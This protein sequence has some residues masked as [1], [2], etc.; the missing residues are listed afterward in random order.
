MFVLTADQ[1]G[2]RR[3]GDRVPAALALLAKIETALPFERTVGDEIQG[4]PADA[5]SALEAALTLIREGGWSIGI[6]IGPGRLTESAPASD[7]EAFIRAREAV[8]RAKGRT[9][10]ISVALNAGERTA[11]VEPLVQ[12]LAV[13][14]GDRSE[15]TWR[16]LDLLAQGR[17]GV[18]V[19]AQ[20]AMSPQNVSNHR[21]RALWD[22][23]VA[24]RAALA[25]LLTAIDD[26]D[27]R[28]T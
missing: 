22:T 2:S 14:V 23:E 26:A 25:R 27:G 5:Q 16:V 21:R 15:A 11:D 20:L 17:S 6:G 10:P 8:E 19:A 3:G 12:L 4:V 1:K 28:A 13:V 24:A 18:E 9:V 7:G